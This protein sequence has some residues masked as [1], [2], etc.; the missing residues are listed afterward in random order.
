MRSFFLKS[1]PKVKK[2]EKIEKYSTK[3]ILK[4][5]SIKIEKNEKDSL[6]SSIEGNVIT[7]KPQQY[8]LNLV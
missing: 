2:T 3:S 1:A 7:A 8:L 4:V 6:G 5:S